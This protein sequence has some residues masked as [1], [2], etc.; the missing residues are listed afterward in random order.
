MYCNNSCENPD[1]KK[2]QCVAFKKPGGD[3]DLINQRCLWDDNTDAPPGCCKDI[4]GFQGCPGQCMDAQYRIPD[5]IVFE[6]IPPSARENQML[7]TQ[8]KNFITTSTESYV[9]HANNLRRIIVPFINSITIQNL[10][11]MIVILSALVISSIL[12]V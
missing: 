5:R 12:M 7:D 6:Q 1:N 11:L 9:T 3:V 10:S 4:K 8:V 2:A